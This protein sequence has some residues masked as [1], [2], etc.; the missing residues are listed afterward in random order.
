MGLG[1]RDTIVMASILA[2]AAH[3][4]GPYRTYLQKHLVMFFV[5]FNVDGNCEFSYF[6]NF[7]DIKR[8][9][10]GETSH[11]KFM[12]RVSKQITAISQAILQK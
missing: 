10:K 11:S 9:Q 4:T 3:P 8:F 7:T 5:G 2:F 1:H 6:S 12:I